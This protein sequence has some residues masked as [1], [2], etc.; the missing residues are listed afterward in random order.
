MLPNHNKGEIMEKNVYEL[1]CGQEVVN[2]QGSLSFHK[3]VFNIMATLTLDDEVDFDLMKQ[4]FNKIVERN[5][6]LRLKFFKQKRKLV[7]IFEDKRVYE[8]IPVLS[9][10]SEQ[11]QEIFLQKETKKVTPFKKGS[12]IDPFYIHTFD[13]KWMI[14]LRVCH[15]AL[16][17][18]GI[19]IIYKDLLDVYN[20]MKNGTDLPEC[21]TSFETMIQADLKKK[22]DENY[23]AKNREFFSN[24]FSTRENPYYAGVHGEDNPI[25]QKQLKKGRHAMKLFLFANKTQGYSHMIDKDL[26]TKTMNYCAE[27]KQTPA[28][29]LFY[30]ASITA[31]KMN[32][33]TKHMLPMELCNCRG[34]VATKKGAGTKAQSVLCYTTVD[35][36]KTF[37]NNFKA[38]CDDQNMVYRHVGFSDMEVQKMLHDYY[39]SSFLEIYYGIAYSFIPMM[40]PKGSHFMIRSNGH[41]A[42]PCYIAQLYRVEEGDIIMAYDA[43]TKIISEK[44]IETFHNNYL[45]V[46]DQVLSN[47]QINIKNIKF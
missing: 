45:K 37:A 19:N 23:N 41:G 6:C 17:V 15:L 33:N 35:Q 1:T 40:M 44:Q 21:P 43:Q 8:N 10:K 46:L 12:V 5:D 32:G 18:Y 28:N 13:G 31:S 9:F 7:Q 16:D 30:V 3:N 34:T 39:K 11:E 2:L 38:F 42:L 26:T 14:V 20:A 22:H 29:L 4:A 24:Y 47:P 27:V 25:W 36:E